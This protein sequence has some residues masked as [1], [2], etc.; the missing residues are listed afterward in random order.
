MA[1]VALG[2]LAAL[3]GTVEVPVINSLHLVLAAGWTWAALAFCVG[4]ACRSR[5]R[6]AVVAPAALAVGV[7][8]Y[9]VT[10]LVQ[11][12]YRE[13]VNLDDP[14]QG[15]HIYWAGF[16]SKTLFWG[17]AAVVLGLLLGLAGNLGRSAGLRGLGFRVLIP[18]IAIAETSMRLNAEASSQGAVA[19]TTWSVTRLVAVAA[20][21]VLA[22]QEVRARSNRALRPTGR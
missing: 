4:F 7:V 9:Y 13:W 21:V 14:S 18:L 5:V 1:G 8:A 17:V 2:V 10:K 3:L 20:I 22:G 16:L 12:E 11:G 15:T 19:S 6:S